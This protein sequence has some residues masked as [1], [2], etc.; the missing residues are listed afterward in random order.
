MSEPVQYALVLNESYDAVVLRDLFRKKAQE[1]HD[2]A[3]NATRRKSVIDNMR[4]YVMYRD[5]ADRCEHIR[6]QERDRIA[7]K[8]KGAES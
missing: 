2:R 7:A 1:H 5:L 4:N 3:A 8:F 6:K